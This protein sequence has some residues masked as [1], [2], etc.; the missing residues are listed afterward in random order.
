VE[1]VI[2]AL[3]PYNALIYNK[4]IVMSLEASE[5]RGTVCAKTHREVHNGLGKCVQK[6]IGNNVSCAFCAAIEAFLS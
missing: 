2:A 5:E 1:V 4:V 6:H 3:A